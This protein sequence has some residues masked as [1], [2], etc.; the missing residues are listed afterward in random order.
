MVAQQTDQPQ[1][2]TL[3]GGDKPQW[4]SV[5]VKNLTGEPAEIISTERVEQMHLPAAVVKDMR[6]VIVPGTTVLV[7]QASVDPSSTGRETTV[8]DADDEPAKK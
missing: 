7:T 1:V 5:G 3:A 2:M 6:S 4:I 8:L